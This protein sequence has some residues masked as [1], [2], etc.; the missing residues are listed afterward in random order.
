MNRFEKAFADADKEFDSQYAQCLKQLK[1]L[2]EIEITS[3]SP[4]T[5]RQE[6]YQKLIEIVEEATRKNISQS[7]LGAKIR[8]LGE[9]AITIAK[10]ISGLKNLL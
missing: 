3:L 10:N 6:T 1:G 2:S 7:E 4:K 8:S 5:N 9:M